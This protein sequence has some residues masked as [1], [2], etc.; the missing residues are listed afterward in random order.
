M[1]F[2][3]SVALHPEKNLSIWTSSKY[4]PCAP[5]LAILRECRVLVFVAQDVPDRK[6]P[7]TWQFQLMPTWLADGE[8]H[9]GGA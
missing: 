5:S 2:V 7:E 8:T 6:R 9:Q 1:H 3:N 4:V